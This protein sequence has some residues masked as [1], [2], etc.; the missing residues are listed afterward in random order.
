MSHSTPPGALRERIASR[1][2]FN[3]AA[4]AFLAAAAIVGLLLVVGSALLRWFAGV[5]DFNPLALVFC[6]RWR[7]QPVR[8]Y[9]AFLDLE[10]DQGSALRAAEAELFSLVRPAG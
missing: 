9:Q 1:D 10:H 7:I 3:V 2:R 8:L 6:A 4:T 5:R